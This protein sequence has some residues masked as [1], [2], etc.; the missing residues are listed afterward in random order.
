MFLPLKTTFFFDTGKNSNSTMF[1]IIADRNFLVKA[2][3][4]ICTK[5]LAVRS[6]KRVSLYYENLCINE[7]TYEGAIET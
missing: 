5:A 6:T 1:R 3:Y 4:I 7:V 2:E